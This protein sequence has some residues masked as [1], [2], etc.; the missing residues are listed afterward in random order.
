[1]KKVVVVCDVKFWA[2]YNLFRALKKHLT[3]WQID[4]AYTTECSIIKHTNYDV[5]LFLCDYQVGLIRWNKIPKEKTILAIRSNVKLRF[6]ENEDLN[7]VAYIIAVANSSL[8]DRFDKLHKNVV[9]APGG[10]DLDIFKFQP[11]SLSSKLRIGWSGSR[12][13]FGGGLRGINLII[14]ACQETGHKFVPAFREDKWRTLEEMNDY[15]H[16]EIDVYVDMSF[17]A[18]RQNGLLEA[19]ACGVPVIASRA[20]FSEQ[21]IKN[22]ENGLLCDRDVESL[23][24]C[25]NNVQEKQNDYVYKMFD[26]VKKKWSWEAQSIIFEKMFKQIISIKST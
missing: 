22:N 14:Q 23:K 7:D 11:K 8:K 18:G 4:D 17:E 2:F 21:L 12:S 6:Y 1:M 10:V 26:T 5:I 25:L 24:T 20:G 13:N 19:A 3:N 9:L 15:Y 16:N